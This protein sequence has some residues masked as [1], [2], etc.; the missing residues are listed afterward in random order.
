MQPQTGIS[1]GRAT[2]ITRDELKFAKF[3]SRM[4]KKFN[5]LFHD[6]LRTQLILKGVI[7]EKDWDTLKEKIQYRYAQD[8]YFEEMKSA[9]NIRNRLDLLNMVQPFVGY[10]YSKNYV[11]KNVLRMTDN[12]IKQMDAEISDEGPPPQMATPDGAPINNAVPQ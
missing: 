12:D 9:E 7:V 5:M 1:F 10:Y 6:L 4:R 2:E 3:V 11:M 8:Q